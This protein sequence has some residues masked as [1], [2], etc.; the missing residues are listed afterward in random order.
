MRF[1]SYYRYFNRAVVH[2]MVVT[3]LIGLFI[4]LLICCLCVFGVSSAW[5]CSTYAHVCVCTHTSVHLIWHWYTLSPHPCP[6]PYS[7]EIGYLTEPGALIAR[8]T[9]QSI[10]LPPSLIALRWQACVTMPP[11]YTGFRDPN[12]GPHGCAVS[13]T[14][15][16][17]LSPAMTGF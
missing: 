8:E 11:F 9:Q 3:A 5:T 10:L 14:A 16:S 17:A 1:F 7:F 6:P 13:T 12:S 15:P 4:Y 2:C